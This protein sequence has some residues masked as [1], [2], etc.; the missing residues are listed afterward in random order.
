MEYKEGEAETEL[1]NM[2]FLLQDLVSC[3]ILYVK[4]DQIFNNKI[5]IRK[6]FTS[7]H[8]WYYT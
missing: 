8:M 2:N 6:V 1:G 3:N 5:I 7:A 4:L